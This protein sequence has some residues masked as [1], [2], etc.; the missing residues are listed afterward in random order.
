[1][2]KGWLNLEPKHVA[3]SRQD[4]NRFYTYLPARA[5]YHL[6]VNVISQKWLSIPRITSIEFGFEVMQ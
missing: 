1:M 2:Q 4:P 3:I 5:P 6:I